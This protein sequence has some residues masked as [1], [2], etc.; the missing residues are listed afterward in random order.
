LSVGAALRVTLPDWPRLGPVDITLSE[1]DQPPSLVELK[2][3]SGPDALGPCAWDL[4]KL[5]SAV[6]AGA[7][8]AG[9]MLAATTRAM[10]DRPARGADIFDSGAWEAGN[11]RE[12]YA[13]WWRSWEKRGD[14]R[15]LRVPARGQTAALGEA[16]FEAGG[17]TWQL[18]LARV[19]ADT[20][21]WVGW[22]QLNPP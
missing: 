2:C 11:V 9:Y 20:D 10:W 17:A 16:A 14:P 21:G 8:S 15:P 22:A 18:R 12:L 19:E 3:G 5:A 4:L 1:P 6:V 13:D 7:G